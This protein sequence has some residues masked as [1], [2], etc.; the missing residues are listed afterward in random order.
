VFKDYDPA[1]RPIPLDGEWMER[2][3]YNLVL[4]AAQASSEGAIVTLRTRWLKDG[5]EIAVID[6]GQGIAAADRE[7]I[8]NP[9]FT[10]KK[11][12]VGLGLPIVAKIVSEH[13][14]RL[15]VESEPG[16]GSAFRVV[17]PG[18]VGD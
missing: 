6:R 4:N 7:S 3:I 12:G 9:F 10:T 2:V 5:V 8:F 16:K 1:V 14:G 18:G 15:D 17:L 11:D 13:G